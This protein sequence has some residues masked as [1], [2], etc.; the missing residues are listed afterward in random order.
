MVL[1]ILQVSPAY[2]PAISIGGPIFS[3]LALKN[4]LVLNGH[5]VT[6]LTTPLGLSDQDADG[7][8]YGVP[9][10]LQPNHE[11][12]YQPFSG[13]A[14][15]TWSPSTMRWLYR[16]AKTF[17]VVIL[18][19]VWN[20]PLL[21]A[22]LI[23]Q[24]QGIPYVLYPHGTLYKETITLRSERKKRLL[25]AVFVRRMLSRAARVVFTTSDEAQKV[26]SYLNLSLKATILPNI[27]EPEEFST[28]PAR[29]SLRTILGIPNDH[30]VL[31]HLGRIASKKGLGITIDVLASLQA[32]G[33]KVSLVVAGG[34]EAG[35]QENLELK[36]EHLGIRQFVHFTGLLDRKN[37]LH[38]LSD[39][40]VFIL[41]SLSENFGMAVVESMLSGVPVVISDQ[42]GLAADIAAANA[43]VVVP[44]DGGSAAFSRAVGQLLDMDEYRL[45]LAETGRRFAIQNY[46]NAAVS[47]K[48][49]TLL[50][51]VKSETRHER[52]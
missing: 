18:H 50:N 15:F 48:L 44:L 12:V 39:A 8:S 19:G 49:D 5:F 35:Q 20:F 21:A 34:D 43:G 7:V 37:T 26:Q 4:L 51:D 22:A 2:F 9:V 45:N 10:A 52:Q 30:A 28:L 38:A 25:L 1:R 14:H 17:D 36:A 3:S 29:G 40:D 42:V 11:I 24:L 31:L 13:Y 41:P 23:S 33:H 32:T 47:N 46:S 27:V 6:T 16:H